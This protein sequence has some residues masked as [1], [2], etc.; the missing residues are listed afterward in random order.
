MGFHPWR[1]SAPPVRLDGAELARLLPVP[2]EPVLPYDRQLLLEEALMSEILE[3]PAGAQA[4]A[5]GVRPRRRAWLRKRYIVVS[6]ALLAL[7]G[8]A[9]AATLV[10][11][12]APVTSTEQVRCYP[13]A[14][15]K[16]D[17]SDIEGVPGG[18][19]PV[20]YGPGTVTVDSALRGCASLWEGGLMTSAGPS[21]LKG[22][23]QPIIVPVARP[24]EGK[25]PP[26]TACVGE[27][28]QAAVFPGEDSN[29]C[30]TLGMPRMVDRG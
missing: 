8:G 7:G 4:D 27:R 6:S 18:D 16:G 24:G 15:L 9:L 3:V 26:L 11:G 25:V 19:G 22:R 5:D 12:D 21:D 13:T 23:K 30:Q 10:F 2:G 29:I 1:R 28:G 20:Y 14:S 17:A